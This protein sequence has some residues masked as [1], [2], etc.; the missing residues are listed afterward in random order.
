MEVTGDAS[1]RPVSAG[2]EAASSKR[3]RTGPGSPDGELAAWTAGLELAEEMVPLLGKLYRRHN[4]VA[5]V[6]GHSLQNQGPV[7]IL[8]IHDRAR[9]QYDGGAGIVQTHAL[10]VALAELDVGACRVDLG[11]MAA[12]FAAGKAG[13]SSSGGAAAAASGGT[14]ATERA[15]LES[16]LRSVLG[17]NRAPLLSDPHGQDVVLFG[18]GRIGRLLARVLVGKTGGGDKL[19]LRAIV[20]RPTKGGPGADLEKRATLLRIDSV[21]GAF[22]GIVATDAARNALIVNGNVVQLLYA[23]GPEAIDYTAHGIRNAI[24]VDN[25]GVFR[26]R[27]ALSRHLAAPGVAKVV[28]TAP[29]ASE[30]A[31]GAGATP[32]STTK[33]VPNI[34]MG[35]NEGAI[36]PSETIVAAASCTTNATCPVLKALNDRFGIVSGHI[37][38]VHSFTNDQNLIDNFHAKARRGRS[39]ALNMVITETGAAAAVGKAMPELAGKLTGNAIRVPTPNVSMAILVLQLREATSADGINEFLRQTSLQGPLQHQIDFS[40]SPEMVSSDFVGSAAAGVVDSVAT[41]V[42]AA[43]PTRVNL[44]VWYD[45]EFGYSSQVIRLTQLLGGVVHPKFPQ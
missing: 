6:F 24:V 17:S 42:S 34:V 31:G 9:Q 20:V 16:E 1:K 7:G 15:F 35:V 13:D 5:T 11:K 12:S 28:L 41:I 19:R 25:T 33:P 18:F 43:D 3:A 14:G 36:E 38:T 45:N 21:H 44:Y 32:A 26:D 37:E 22:D 27:A 8:R 10:L 40:A 23:A 4:V 2:A 30:P 29:S 39:A